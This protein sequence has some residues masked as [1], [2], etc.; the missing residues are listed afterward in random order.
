VSK[1]AMEKKLKPLMEMEQFSAR[2]AA[3]EE[4]E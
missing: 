1:G 3:T 2:P 4:T